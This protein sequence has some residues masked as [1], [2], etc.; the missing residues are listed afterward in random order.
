MRL[1]ENCSSEAILVLRGA[2]RGENIED[3]FGKQGDRIARRAN[4]ICDRIGD[5]GGG[6]INRELTDAF[7]PKG[8]VFVAQFLKEYSDARHVSRC[9]HDVVC[10]LAVLHAAVLP[11]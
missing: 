9:W 8:A 5:G 4:C 3:V 2:I 11:N 10:H 7:C 6:T 1:V